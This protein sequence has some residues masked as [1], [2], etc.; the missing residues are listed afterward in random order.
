MSSASY[1]RHIL[2]TLFAIAAASSGNIQ[3]AGNTPGTAQPVKPSITKSA[4]M[5]VG[6]AAF[7]K[8][9]GFSGCANELETLDK[10]LF[11]E[12]DYS[13]RAFLAESNVNSRPFS[14]L[15]DS[16]KLSAQGTYLR[17]LTNVVVTPGEA[18][19]A[20][21]T[22]MYEQTL[23]HDQHCDT[24][25][26]QMAASAKET[27]VTSFGSVTLDLLRNMTLTVIPVGSGQCVTVVKE[28]AY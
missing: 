9:H 5:K 12:S 21:C 7:A 18:K 2:V 6:L 11:L 17:A 27:G 26:A 4:P 13:M 22:T 15:I 19:A 25:R 16:R 10:N 8:S 3:A 28:V 14:A 23:Y 24:V 20:R 1:V